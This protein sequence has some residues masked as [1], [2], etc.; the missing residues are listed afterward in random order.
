M[1][2]YPTLKTSQRKLTSG[3]LVMV[4]IL[5]GCEI[6]AWSQ[7][8]PALHYLVSV[9]QPASHKYHVELRKSG[10]NQDTLVFKIPKWMPGYYQIMDY[11]KSVESISVTDEKGMEFPFSKIS[12]NTLRISGIRNKTY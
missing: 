11:A 10:W 7:P 6:S 3:K 8:K 2:K 1:N 4:F 5:I 9:P 12:D